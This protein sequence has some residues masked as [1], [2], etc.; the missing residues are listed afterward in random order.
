[1]CPAPGT[2]PLIL[3]DDGGELRLYRNQAE[4]LE[5]PEK[6]ESTRCIIDPAGQYYHLHTGPG[7]HLLLSR[8]IGQVEHRTLLEHFLN[9]QH[10]NLQEHRLLRCYAS[11]R[12]E[13]LATIFE[14]LQIEDAADHQAWT[15]E[16]DHQTWQCTG[17]AAVDA[18]VTNA[19]SPA[20]VTDPFGRRYRPR[21]PT[22]G[23]LARRLKGRPLY[24]EIFRGNART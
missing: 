16:A 8:A 2:V 22:H 1:M 14:E 11:T 3:M 19:R 13:T 5:S 18:H 15:V 7:A 24:V 12:Q 4:L 23:T 20:V 17:L 9:R 6:P 10:R 21:T